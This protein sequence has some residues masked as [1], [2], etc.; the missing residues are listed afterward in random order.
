MAVEGDRL[1]SGSTCGRITISGNALSAKSAFA[2]SQSRRCSDHV[3]A[4][5]F[6]CA[7]GGRRTTFQTNGRPALTLSF[8]QLLASVRRYSTAP[9]Q[10]KDSNLGFYLIGAGTV[11]LGAYAYLNSLTPAVQA[12]K[13][14][15]TSPLDPSN[16]VDFE[17][18]KVEHYN[19]N[20]AKR[21]PGLVLS[22]NANV[23]IRPG[24][25]SS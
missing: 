24:S 4:E 20:T 21:V 8:R 7:L 5:D 19:H 9:T 22:F 6:V 18:K 12:V 14:K 3:D 2:P 15:E 16:F 25:S 11:G 1:K 10:A 17:L 13:L 23:V